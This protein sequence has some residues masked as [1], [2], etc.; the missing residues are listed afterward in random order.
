MSQRVWFDGV[1]TQKIENRQKYYEDQLKLTDS[2]IEILSEAY[3]ER[4]HQIERQFEEKTSLT[5]LDLSILVFTACLQ[6]LRWAIITNKSGRF[7]TAAD[8]DKAVAGL[9]KY[10]PASVESILAD[11]TV[12][13][14]AI[15]R[16]ERFKKIYPELSTGISGANHRYKTL[17][18]DPL[19]GWFVGTANIA[20][21]TLV[22][23]NGMMLYPSYHIVNQEFNGRTHLPNIIKWTVDI[24]Q[25]KPEVLG[26]AFIKQAVHYSTD[27]FTTQGLPLPIINSVSPEASKFLMGHGID[28]YSVT[29]S[30]ALA[31]VINKLV[32]MFHRLFFD[33]KVDDK[34]L[35][36]VRT[37]KIVMYSNILSSVINIGYV[38]G[39]EDFNRLDVGGIAVTLWRILTDTKRIMQ[40]KT[41][42]IEKTLDGEY[43]KE[44]DEI[45]Q[46]L[47]KYGYSI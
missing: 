29:R 21:N 23:N 8:A 45:N 47:A 30:A 16:S 9:G 43:K 19:A 31:M 3:L 20:T 14:D 22:V 39:T 6:C 33:P 11:H 36:E 13:Y 34:D 24:A 17:G 10:M 26:L 4:Y 27:V 5:N 35:Y 28:L 12:P 7:A 2:E 37:R 38:A 44:E 1:K 18:H 46:Q 40:L 41:E 32:E 42:F 15:K 25:E